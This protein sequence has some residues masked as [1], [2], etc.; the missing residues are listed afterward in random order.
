MLPGVLREKSKVFSRN[1][2]GRDGEARRRTGTC[3]SSTLGS[4]H[5]G[6]PP[7][8]P[9]PVPRPSA[10]DTSP[11]CGRVR[12]QVSSV[13]RYGREWGALGDTRLH[14]EGGPRQTGQCPPGGTAV[15]LAEA[16]QACTRA[17]GGGRA[18]RTLLC[19]T[20]FIKCLPLT[21]HPDPRIPL[22]TTNT[23]ILRGVG[24]VRIF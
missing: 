9:T 4:V 12:V 13:N 21:P 11:R 2:S 17:A 7:Q 24:S 8:C 6:A 5:H 10:P 16:R 14:E 3:P 22:P 18:R 1:A 15:N 23:T 19:Q 20:L